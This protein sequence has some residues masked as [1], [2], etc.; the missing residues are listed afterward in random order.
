MKV[1]KRQTGKDGQEKMD[2]RRQRGEDDDGQ[3]K[4]ERGR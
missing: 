4:T 2:R 1:D 3:E